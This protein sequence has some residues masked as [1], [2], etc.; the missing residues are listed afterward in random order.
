[1]PNELSL[2]CF[3]KLVPVIVEYSFIRMA[4]VISF[5]ISHTIALR[6]T[7]NDQPSGKKRTR[8]LRWII[9][10]QVKTY[11]NDTIMSF[12]SFSAIYLIWNVKQIIMI[13]LML[14]L[15]HSFT[16]TS[17]VSWEDWWTYDGISGKLCEMI[18]IKSKSANTCR[19]GH[20]MIVF[21]C[22]NRIYF[23]L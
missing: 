3:E 23:K 10:L 4:V 1:M 7:T 21:S 22:L 15:F 12:M 11:W 20:I 2:C 6:L 5:W 18:I 14:I 13:K 8:M 9:Y 17:A 19:L 16:V